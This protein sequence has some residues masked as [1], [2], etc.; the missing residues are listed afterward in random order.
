MGT[1]CLIWFGVVLLLDD[2]QRSSLM[3][4]GHLLPVGGHVCP[5]SAAR[6]SVVRGSLRSLYPDNMG[7]PFP[8]LDGLPPTGDSSVLCPRLAKL[9]VSQ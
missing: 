9:T 3:T 5:S 1:S 2:D 7:V 6:L 8:T 4:N